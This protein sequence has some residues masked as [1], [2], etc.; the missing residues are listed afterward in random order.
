M[1][2]PLVVEKPW[3][4]FHQYTHNEISTVKIITVKPHEQLSLQSHQHRDELWIA[5]DGNMIAIVGEKHI[6]LAPLQQ[7]FIPKKVKHRLINE[8]NELIKILEISFG[9][10]NE[11]DI[12]RYDDKYG[13]D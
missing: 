7:T 2:E 6:P 8:S 5:I 13:R 3:G 9:S 11:T 10:F 4:F 12:I 1:K